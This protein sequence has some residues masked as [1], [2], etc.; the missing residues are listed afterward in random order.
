[1]DNRELAKMLVELGRVA[2]FE[3]SLVA[4][5][6]YCM[7]SLLVAGDGVAYAQMR[8]LAQLAKEIIDD[9]TKRH[10]LNTGQLPFTVPDRILEPRG[11]YH[12]IATRWQ[13]DIARAIL[14]DKNVAPP[15]EGE[16]DDHS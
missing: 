13:R 14:L 10:S 12:H 1:M 9:E 4:G 6:C 8:R 15:A 5:M 3:H 16:D 7:A 11:W 2:G